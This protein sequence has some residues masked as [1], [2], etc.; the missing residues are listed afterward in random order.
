M[1][2]AVE[3]RRL[4]RPNPVLL[5][6]ALTFALV[7]GL[8]LLGV[9]AVAV[10]LLGTDW[11]QLPDSRGS[12]VV[13]L[14]WLLATVGECGLLA[15]PL[16]WFARRGARMASPGWDARKWPLFALTAALLGVLVV[17]SSG[18]WRRRSSS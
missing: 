5:T 6:I 14:W 13:D 3:P 2:V 17:A 10:A 18:C 12:R 7:T 9:V 15:A 16:T 8:F 1:S 4:R 11:L